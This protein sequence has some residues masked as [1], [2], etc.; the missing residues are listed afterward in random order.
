MMRTRTL[1]FALLSFCFPVTG[2]AQVQTVQQPVVRQFGVGTA[3]SV[4]DRGRAHLGGIS[5]GAAGRKTYGPLRNGTSS[6]IEYS[7]SS[8]SASVYI[9]DFDA[10]DR[11]L[12]ETAER[13]SIRR[14][15]TNRTDSAKIHPRAERAWQTLQTRQRTQR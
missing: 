14:D 3:V 15:G 12:L 13:E 7:T 9:F 6:G 5:K 11:E 8:Q 1:Y 10:M 4:P 2:W